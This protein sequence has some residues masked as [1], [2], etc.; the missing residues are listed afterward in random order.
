MID[1]SKIA[2]DL[3][4]S[5]DFS[6][7][8]EQGGFIVFKDELKVW[9]AKNISTE[10][11]KFIPRA[12]DYV[13][14]SRQ[15]QIVAIY[16]NHISDTEFSPQDKLLAASQDLDIILVRPTHE[17]LIYRPAIDQYNCVD[18]VK[19]YYKRLGINLKIPSLNI[20]DIQQI[21]QINHLT[22][23]QTFDPDAI[24]VIATNKGYHL[25]ICLNDTYYLHYNKTG[26]FR[27]FIPKQYV[28]HIYVRPKTEI[29]N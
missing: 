23:S 24:L 4:D 1:Y 26:E 14:A 29:G 16:H 22:E 10:P 6:K 28:T 7:P 18:F 15:G 9:P 27:S 17:L 2:N 3:I 12:R 11:N 20:G 21:A 5:I 25:G 8:Q 19:D 13:L